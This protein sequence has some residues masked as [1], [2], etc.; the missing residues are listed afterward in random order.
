MGTPNKL[1]VMVPNYINID[2]GSCASQI[3]IGIVGW[4]LQVLGIVPPT[5]WAPGEEPWILSCTPYHQLP[6][7]L[8]IG[9][10]MNI[11][12]GLESFLVCSNSS[13][14]AWRQLRN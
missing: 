1:I 6:T 4:L 7:Q 13:L 5:Q 14:T 2:Q 8:C 11:T 12:M 9:L 3:S 10:V